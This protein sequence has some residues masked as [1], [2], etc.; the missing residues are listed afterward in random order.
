MTMKGSA[1]F[2]ADFV[3]RADVRMVQRRSRLRLAL[4]AGQSLWVFGD[5]IGK[6][7]QG[8]ESVQ[9]Y[10]LGFV[11]HTHAAATELLDDAE[12][13]DGAADQ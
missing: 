2:V 7:L 5:F 3:D 8:G 9:G 10:V 4:K 6:K 11:D 1:V 12:V 13:G